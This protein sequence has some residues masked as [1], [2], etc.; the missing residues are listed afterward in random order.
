MRHSDPAVAA[1]NAAETVDPW[2]GRTIA[3]E[4]DLVERLGAGVQGTVY[5][6]EQ[7]PSG[8]SVAVKLLTGPNAHDMQHRMRFLREVRALELLDHP[9]IVGLLRYGTLRDEGPE[10]GGLYIVEELVEGTSLE[11]VID[12]E[13]ALAP[14]RA[15]DIARQVLDALAVAHRHGVVH[16][17]IKPAH[18]LLR[19]D[20]FGHEQVTLIDFGLA[21]REDGF[22]DDDED[23]TQAGWMLGS[24]L[25]M[26][27]EPL[28]ELPVGP[29]ADQYSLGVVLFE[30]LAGHAPF[31]G[32][33]ETVLLGHA[34]DPVP[35]LPLEVDPTGEL[36][37]VITR[38]MAKS[39]SSRFADP[40]AM[41]AAL[42]ELTGLFGGEDDTLIDPPSAE[43]L[44]RF[45]EHEAERARDGG[46]GTGSVRR[47][48]A[49]GERSRRR[50]RWLLS[51]SAVAASL[52]VGSAAAAASPWF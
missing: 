24:P 31:R 44:A 16:R 48:R 10:S 3:G 18:I 33:L 46:D 52:A 8:R 28:A 49:P 26:A 21:R 23:L 6:A 9:S 32:T 13:G 19:R 37:A 45:A 51:A 29:A 38:A 5:R 39:P 12:T 17:D 50:S 35:R 7:R 25:Y 15:L 2:I 36:S 11:R 1:P 34:V 4:F 43:L 27:P 14:A 40:R 30:M 47:S 41:S 20:G 42:A 22:D